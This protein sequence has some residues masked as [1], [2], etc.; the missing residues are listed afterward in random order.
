L[1][2]VS[3]LREAYNYSAT[4]RQFK[5]E[6]PIGG[7]GLHIDLENM[8]QYLIFAD[9]ASVSGSNSCSPDTTLGNQ[10]FDNEAG[11]SP[12]C[13]DG[14]VGSFELADGIIFQKII[15]SKEN[16]DTQELV[17][18]T[19][20]DYDF[21]LAFRSFSSFPYVGWMNNAIYR[22]P[23]NDNYNSEKVEKVEIYL[24][25]QKMDKCRKV[26]ILGASASIN[27]ELTPCP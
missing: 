11:Y 18:I 24:K 26:T 21:D 14:I 2:L 3:H 25:H 5:G 15:I 17:G 1:A 19:S 10:R 27:E 23:E 6:V 8:G 13:N 16:G 20:D 4:G 12:R 7:Y 9:Q 22:D